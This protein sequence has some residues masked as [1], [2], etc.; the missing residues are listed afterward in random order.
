MNDRFIGWVS[1]MAIGIAL[2]LFAGSALAGQEGAFAGTWTASGTYQPLE[3]AQGREIFTFRLS[4]H[5]N[6]K[7]AIGEIADLWSECTGLWDAQTGSATCGSSNFWSF[8]S[9]SGWAPAWAASAS[10]LPAASACW[11]WRWCS[12]QARQHP[13]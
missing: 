10:A 9:L 13:D 11:C 2:L 5:V 8:C 1:A 6:L 12:D 3:F 4:G 7:T